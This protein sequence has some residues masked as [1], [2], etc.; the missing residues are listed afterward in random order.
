MEIHSIG[1][2]HSHE[3]DFVIDRPDGIGQSWLFLLFHTN[4]QMRVDGQLRILPENTCIIYTGETPEYYAAYGKQYMDDWFHF[5]VEKR[6]IQLL[7][8]LDIP[9]NK[10][11]QLTN[12]SECSDL[13]RNM[14]Y[15][16]YSSKD[17][18][19]DVVELL[20][21][22]LMIQISRQLH[23]YQPLH[24]AKLNVK[25]DR[26]VALRGRI[27]S[28]IEQIGPVSAIAEELSMSISSLQHS[29]KTLFGVSIS[30]D[31]GKARAE[32]A[33]LLLSTT[34]LPL[35]QIAALSGY[36]SEFHFM[37][38]FKGMTGLTPTEYREQ[39]K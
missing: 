31:I 25:A 11:L 22:V 36:H 9:L 34:T 21:K 4:V 2:H 19:I 32:K 13:I 18:H 3:P 10:P 37:R 6:D 26:L 20:M 29:Y 30:Q 16:F 27:Y 15:E 5:T 39:S 28:Q 24:A 8:E 38:Q 1:Y 12:A 7:R 33:K 14:T 35:R 23:A 17:Y